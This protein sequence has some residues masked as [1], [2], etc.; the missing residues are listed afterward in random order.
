MVCS[1]SAGNSY[2][3][4][5]NLA[6]DL[7]IDDVSMHTGGSPGTYVN[8]LCT[9]AADDI[10]MTGTPLVY[11]GQNFYYTETASTGAAMTSIAGTHDF[12][13]IDSVGD[14]DGY[15]AVNDAV[16]LFRKDRDREPW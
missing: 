4:T 13:Y 14:V 8:S 5:Q 1:I 16:G 7:F 2:A 10:G 15:T 11:N 3:L 6:T 9:A 12:V